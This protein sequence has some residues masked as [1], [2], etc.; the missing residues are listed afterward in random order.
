[1]AVFTTRPEFLPKTYCNLEHSGV[2]QNAQ[3]GAAM[4]SLK[5]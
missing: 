3:A 1:M 2:K 4:L 5:S